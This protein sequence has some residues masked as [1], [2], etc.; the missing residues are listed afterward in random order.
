V[1]GLAY[2]PARVVRRFSTAFA[3]P[4][5]PLKRFFFLSYT[6][7]SHPN[8]RKSGANWGPRLKAR[9]TRANRTHLLRNC[10]NP[11][12]PGL[13]PSWLLCAFREDGVPPNP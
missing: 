9:T 11:R 3:A 4:K 10:S 6:R 7:A 5:R 1:P 2:P 8:S 12:K 13:L